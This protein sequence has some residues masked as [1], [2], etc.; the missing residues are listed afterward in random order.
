MI[1]LDDNTRCIID[2]NYFFNLINLDKQR[3][4]DGFEN[5][6]ECLDFFKTS[7]YYSQIKFKKGSKLNHDINR[8]SSFRK[9]IEEKSIEIK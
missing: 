7:K 4:I 6:F 5:E 2:V 9:L 3:F 8:L 1:R